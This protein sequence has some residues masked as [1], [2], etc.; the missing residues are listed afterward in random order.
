[1]RRGRPSCQQ[2]RNPVL[3]HIVLIIRLWAATHPSTPS[4]RSVSLRSSLLVAL[5]LSGSV[6]A[7]Q[8]GAQA[9]DAPLP[10]DSTVLRGRLPNGLRYLIRRNTL[11]EKR[12]ELRL[13]VDAG[14]ILEDEPQLGLAHFVEHMAFNG[15][16]RFPKADLVELP[17]AIGVRFGPDLNA[18]TSFDETVYMLQVP[19]DTAAIVS[20]AL[21]ILED[22]AH[23]LALDSAEIR[24]ERGVV[25]E[26]WRSGRGAQM[27]MTD[28][29]FPV[30]L[31]G[32][33]Y[34]DA[35]ADRHAREP[36]VVPGQRRARLLPR[37][38]PAR[39]S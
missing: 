9:A 28:K 16:R 5:V 31:R 8:A 21:D 13:V 25:V 6:L 26:E 3:A 32:S 17:R 15:T 23:G 4:S 12:A 38:V 29:Q 2:V 37:L 35:A 39:T 27:R 30:I 18:Y 11:P 7:P 33:K 22:W 10:F 24:K 1:M 36:A 34:A 20:K 14:S 19:T